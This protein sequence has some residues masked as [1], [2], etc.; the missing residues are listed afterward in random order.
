[1]NSCK[2]FLT[3]K[4][5]YSIWGCLLEPFSINSSR[6]TQGRSLIYDCNT[7]CRIFWIG[8]RMLEIFSDICNG[9]DI[10]INLAFCLCY[11]TVSRV[12]KF[13][14][15]SWECLTKPPPLIHIHKHQ[16]WDAAI[17]MKCIE[18]IRISIWGLAEICVFVL[19]VVTEKET[20]YVRCAHTVVINSKCGI[21]I[22]WYN[23]KSTEYPLK[24][25]KDRK[26]TRNH[27]ALRN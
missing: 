8:N 6:K 4:I 18:T 10:T 5:L 11:L 3:K 2:H 21:V 17:A 25:A 26:I 13:C 20:W 7:F 24:I 23:F 19:N 22:N 27:C 12:L 14:R 15:I 9:I 1:M 16:R